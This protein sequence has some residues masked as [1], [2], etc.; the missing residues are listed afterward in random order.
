MTRSSKLAVVTLLAGLL[1]LV[2]I[3]AVNADP[4]ANEGRAYC[5]D[6]STVA[7][8]DDTAQFHITGVVTTDTSASTAGYK[9]AE[10]NTNLGM[11]NE[12]LAPAISPAIGFRFIE[13]NTTS[14]PAMSA[15]SEEF[16]PSMGMPR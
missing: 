4:C 8:A 13:S 1:S 16:T 9:F 2:P 5:A 7:A 15:Y 12:E 14:L 3:S 6:A 11:V 10:S